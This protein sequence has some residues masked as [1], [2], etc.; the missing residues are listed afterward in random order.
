MNGVEHYAYL[1]D[2]FTRLANGLLEKD[3]NALGSGLIAR[4]IRLQQVRRQ[5]GGFL[6]VGRTAWRPYA[7]P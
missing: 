1:R 7:N 6:R 2:L 3:I 4:T 5:T